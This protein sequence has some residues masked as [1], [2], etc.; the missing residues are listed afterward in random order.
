MISRQTVLHPHCIVCGKSNGQGL[1]LSFQVCEDG[2]VEGRFFCSRKFQGYNGLLHGGVISSILDGAMTNCLF[3]SGR[4]AVTGKLTVRFSFPVLIDREIVV[5]AR[6]KKSSPPLHAM[7]SEML[8]D[9]RIVSRASA[10]FMEV[11]YANNK[12][13]VG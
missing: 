9:G 7:E 2:G 1:N 3:S 11:E 13:N 12:F 8:Q 10:K 4:T 5:R 6:I